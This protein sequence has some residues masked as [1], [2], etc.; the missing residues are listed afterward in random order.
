MVSFDTNILV[1]ATG[2]APDGKT[3]RARDIIARGMR[4]GWCVLLLQT[5]DFARIRWIRNAFSV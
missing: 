3:E 2:A 5:L 4:S 1:Y